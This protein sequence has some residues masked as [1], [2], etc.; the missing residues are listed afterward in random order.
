MPC[1]MEADSIGRTVTPAPLVCV[2][3]CLPVPA[4]R[5]Y[6]QSPCV[7][8][9]LLFFCVDVNWDRSTLV[10]SVNGDLSVGNSEVQTGS[11]NCNL[12]DPWMARRTQLYKSFLDERYSVKTS[13]SSCLAEFASKSSCRHVTLNPP[14]VRPTNDRVHKILNRHV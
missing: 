3:G 11:L 13:A 8:L 10:Y 14:V 1:C 7:T 2:V 5:R 9:S 12:D 6:N 4:V